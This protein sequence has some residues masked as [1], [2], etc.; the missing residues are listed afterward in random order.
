MEA[1]GYP[2]LD[3]QKD[4]HQGFTRHFDKLKQEI[5][6]GS[7]S[8]RYFLLFKIQLL[9]MDWLVHHTS[10]SDRHLGKFI[11]LQKNM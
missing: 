1:S 10:K 4:Q 9:I 5:Q 3:V 8:D 7:G 11:R 2:F 6:K